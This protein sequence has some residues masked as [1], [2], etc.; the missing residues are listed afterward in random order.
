MSGRPVHL[1]IDQKVRWLTDPTSETR[2][3]TDLYPANPISEKLW[4]CAEPLR[5]L[6]NLLEDSQGLKNANKK[7]RRLKVLI[8]PLYSLYQAIRNLKNYYDSTSEYKDHKGKERIRTVWKQFIEEVPQETIQTIRDKLSGHIDK[9]LSP[10][11][12]RQI[13]A[14]TTP[15]DIGIWIHL[16]VFMLIEL[17]NLENIHAWYT[18]D[19]PPD[20]WKLMTAESVLVTLKVEDNKPKRIEGIE[21]VYSPRYEISEICKQVIQTSQWMF[22]PEDPKIEIKINVGGTYQVE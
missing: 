12:A 18:E 16:C 11:Q 10:E 4:R 3:I 13:L 14:S 8:T 9:K 7:R 19:C 6:E 22:R 21:F 17:L 2:Q 1:Y 5:D 15:R 20:H